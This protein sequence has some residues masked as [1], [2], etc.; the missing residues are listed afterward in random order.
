MARRSSDEAR[1][2]ALER[3]VGQLTMENDLSNKLESAR[4]RSR[5]QPVE[6]EEAHDLL[7]CSDQVDRGTRRSRGLSRTL[8]IGRPI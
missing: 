4:G 8:S 6:V 2:A 5:A 3:K 1:I 7:G